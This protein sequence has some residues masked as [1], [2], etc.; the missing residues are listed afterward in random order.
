MVF[1]RSWSTPPLGKRV[2]RYWRRSLVMEPENGEQLESCKYCLKLKKCKNFLCFE[3]SIHW[4]QIIGDCFSM[5]FSTYFLNHGQIWLWR[6]S[7][8]SNYFRYLWTVCEWAGETT[9]TILI[10]RTISLSTLW[11]DSL[12]SRSDCVKREPSKKW[13]NSFAIRPVCQLIREAAHGENSHNFWGRKNS[14]IELH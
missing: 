11:Q 12:K 7:F 9:R 6:I 10:L 14:K 8:W 4:S 13:A 5:H 1:W 3:E 2:F